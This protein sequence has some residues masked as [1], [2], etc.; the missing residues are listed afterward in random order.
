[1]IYNNF[2]EVDCLS[3][4][5]R[6]AYTSRSWLLILGAIAYNLIGTHF[7]FVAS[8]IALPFICY[9]VFRPKQIYFLPLMIF[10]QYGL[11]AGYFVMLSCFFY[12]LFHTETLHK[13][14]AM[15]VFLLYLAGLP[16]FVWYTYTRLKSSSI[17][18]FNY[19]SSFS[20]L[21]TYLSF[22]PFFWAA[23]FRKA[24]TREFFRDLL[25]LSILFA[26]VNTFRLFNPM[27]FPFIRFAFWAVCY[28]GMY[29]IWIL[30]QKQQLK[31]KYVFVCSFISICIVVSFLKGGEGAVTF[32]QL[33]SII[34]GS[35][36][37]YVAARM[38]HLLFA[39]MPAMILILSNFY[40]WGSAS[41]SEAY[42]LDNMG[43]NT[44]YKE[45]RISNIS[46][47]FNRL[48]KKAF[49]DRAGVWAASVESVKKIWR[50]HPVWIP[51][52]ADV[53]QYTLY[54]AHGEVKIDTDLG[55]HNTFLHCIR[56]FGFYGGLVV[57]FVFLM[58][59]G[60][61]GRLKFIVSNLSSEYSIC[62]ASCLAQ[63]VCSGI[64]G[65]YCVLIQF[66]F[67]IWGILGLCHAKKYTMQQ[68]Y[69]TI[70]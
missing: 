17:E 27:K 44:S 23:T 63:G 51:P 58:L 66:G 56:G 41:R 59:L 50:D 25:L 49:G 16:F 55:A 5:E 33:F 36:L 7:A 10:T 68:M 47:F 15:G 24:Y 13:R 20:S 60:F 53:M 35:A 8:I 37:L 3:P 40:V 30:L 46:S 54:T 32:T 28:C 69:S 61:R 11:Q 38:K 43:D 52:E 57:Y 64:T 26:L 62:A 39:F 22:A 4:A 42:Q 45:I 48:E 70:A 6:S 9:M 14:K 2:I 31:S 18:G 65:Q 67:V 29:L 12:A 21:G 1:M 19:S 34:F